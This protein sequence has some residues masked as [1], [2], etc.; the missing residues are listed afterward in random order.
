MRTKDKSL[1][2]NRTIVPK[3]KLRTPR[4]RKCFLPYLSEYEPMM[5]WIRVA[6]SVPIKE[7]VP[8]IVRLNPKSSKRYTLRFGP[9]RL[10]PKRK[11]KNEIHNTNIFEN[12][13]CS[14]IPS[15]T[16]SSVALHHW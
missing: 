9:S 11:M 16:P 10:I 12:D 1:A 15:N 4:I 6:R 7:T 2:K 5:G 13:S 8:T 3:V 14:L